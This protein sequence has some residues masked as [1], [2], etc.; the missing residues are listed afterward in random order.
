MNNLMQMLRSGN[1]QQIL[2]QLQN[3]PDPQMRQALQQFNIANNQMRQSGMSME[4]YVK[5]YAR[6]N[7][8][9]INQIANQLGIKL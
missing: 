1:V 5:Q 3:S 4:Q 6:Q 8:I 9:N 2:T 7:N